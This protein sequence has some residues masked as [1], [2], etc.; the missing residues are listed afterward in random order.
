M[1]CLNCCDILSVWLVNKNKSLQRV[2][3]LNDYNRIYIGSYFCSRLFLD[4][5]RFDKIISIIKK[6][7]VPVTLVLPIVTERDLDEMKKRIGK[8]IQ[9]Y[10]CIDEITVNDFGM[11]GYISKSYPGIKMNFGR[12]FFKDQRDVRNSDYFAHTTTAFALSDIEWFRAR[13][14]VNAIELDITNKQQ[15]IDK[16]KEMLEIGLHTP[17]TYVSTG[18]ICKF[19][20]IG[21][22]IQ[23][24]FRPNDCCKNECSNIFERYQASSSSKCPNANHFRIG[25]TIYSKMPKYDLDGFSREIYI[26][27]DEIMKAEYN[28]EDSYTT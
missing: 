24:K 2:L 7:D 16:Y 6:L 1:R 22:D 4:Y 12:L 23:H 14:K 18:N 9:S 8:I 17:Y 20:S 27:Y 3:E 15:D 11:A 13:Y 5:I 10:D 26:P 19:A 28:Y 21:K 25:R